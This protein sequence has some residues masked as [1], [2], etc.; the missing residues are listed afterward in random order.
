ME[1]EDVLDRALRNPDYQDPNSPLV[2]AEIINHVYRSGESLMQEEVD[3]HETMLRGLGEDWYRK[4]Y[5]RRMRQG[6]Q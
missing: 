4:E 6:L 3:A 2:D 5:I 1:G